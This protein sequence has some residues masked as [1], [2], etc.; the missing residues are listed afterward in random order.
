ML[1]DLEGDRL[2]AHLGEDAE[3]VVQCSIEE[4]EAPGLHVAS[5]GSELC[6]RVRLH[7]VALEVAL[8]LGGRQTPERNVEVDPVRHS[9]EVALDLRLELRLTRDD[10]ADIRLIEDCPKYLHL[11]LGVLADEFVGLVNDNEVTLVRI[12][13]VPDTVH[14]APYRAVAGGDAER[15][16]DRLD[17]V[18]AAHGVIALDVGDPREFGVLL[19]SVGLAVAGTPDHNA[20]ADVLLAGLADAEDGLRV[21]AL[22]ETGPLGL[23]RLGSS[24]E[25][26]LLARV[27]REVLREAELD[28]LRI[29]V[30]L[31]PQVAGDGCAGIVDR[32]CERGDTCARR[33]EMGLDLL[34]EALTVCVNGGGCR[35][36]DF[37]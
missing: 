17:E 19:E 28:V 22:K 18:A 31:A 30:V 6:Q 15:I 8:D 7:V 14:P 21:A 29:A 5:A 9:H 23:C 10:D 24:R 2:P 25:D 27:L 11:L 16:L 26:D 20:E 34:G 13:I 37:H 1:D 36:C 3:D 32:A 4:A 35:C 12:A 33:F